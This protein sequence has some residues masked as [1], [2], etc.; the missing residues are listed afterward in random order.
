MPLFS[1]KISLRNRNGRRLIFE[2]IGIFI[3]PANASAH[4]SGLLFLGCFSENSPKTEALKGPCPSHTLTGEE[5]GKYGFC[6]GGRLVSAGSDCPGQALS[7]ALR[8]P[9]V[10]KNGSGFFG[11]AQRWHKKRPI[12]RVLMERWAF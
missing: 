3:F 9:F 1:I 10:Q 5:K 6:S 12:R 11:V 8:L 4:I 2:T 7:T